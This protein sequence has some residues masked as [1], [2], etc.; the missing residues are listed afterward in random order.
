MTRQKGRLTIRVLRVS[1]VPVE[2]VGERGKKKRR[3]HRERDRFLSDAGH[4]MIRSLDG[5]QGDQRS[6][7]AP[8]QTGKGAKVRGAEEKDTVLALPRSG[9]RMTTRRRRLGGRRGREGEY[10]RVGEGEATTRDQSDT[11]ST[12]VRSLH[13]S[14]RAHP[15]CGLPACNMC[16]IMYAMLPSRILSRRWRPMYARSR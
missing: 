1:V 14:A 12:D 6:R 11:K 8:L 4:R 15:R 16:N 9:E 2:N 7:A 3:A 5:R 13:T 10:D